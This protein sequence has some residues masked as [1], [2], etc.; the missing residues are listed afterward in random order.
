MILFD[1]RR[2][3][4]FD[5]LLLFDL[6]LLF[7][8]GVLL[9]ASASDAG[10]FKRQIVWATTAI[11]FAVVGSEMCIRDRTTTAKMIAVVAQT[12]CR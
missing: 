7:G 3:G 8:I 10:H 6:S 1:R 2:F 4:A 11:I 5:Y 9:I 12:I